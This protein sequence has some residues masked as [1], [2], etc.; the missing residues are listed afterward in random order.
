MKMEQAIKEEIKMEQQ[1]KRETRE[2]EKLLSPKAGTATSSP[3]NRTT[4]TT[5]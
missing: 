3:V 5:K 1:V 4:S 2:P